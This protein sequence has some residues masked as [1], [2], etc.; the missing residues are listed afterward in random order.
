MKSNTSFHLF[1][2]QIRKKSTKCATAFSVF[3]AKN[4]PLPGPDVQI[5][6]RHVRMALFD[7]NAVLSNIHTT[8]VIYNPDQPKTWKFSSK[9]S[10]LFPKDDE[11]T[12]FVRADQVDFKLCILFELCF[13]VSKVVL[14][15]DGKP[16][17][18]SAVVGEVSC[19]WGVLPLFTAE[20]KP[21]ENRSYEIR[22][23]GGTPLEKD[24][25]L[26]GTNE[27]KNLWQMI[28]NSDKS[29]RLVVKVWKLRKSALEEIK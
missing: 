14:D 27:K 15:K 6:G 17:H 12:C 10:V 20:G 13:L 8:P 22:L 26:I 2:N 5:L 11:N 25:D 19:G 1:A 16:G 29:P 3:E 4:L 21:I 9:S 24:V 23:F 7:K 28:V 18:A